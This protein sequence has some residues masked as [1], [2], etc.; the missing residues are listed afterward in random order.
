MSN[1]PTRIKFMSTTVLSSLL[2]CSWVSSAVAMYSTVPEMYNEQIS[3]VPWHFVKS[4]FHCI[5]QLKHLRRRNVSGVIYTA[6]PIKWI[7]DN[8]VMVNWSVMVWW[9]KLTVQLTNRLKFDWQ[10]DIWF[11]FY[12]QLK[13][14]LIVLC[15]V[16]D[17]LFSPFN[18]IVLLFSSDNVIKCAYTAI[19]RK[20]VAKKVHATISE[21]NMGYDHTV[22]NDCSC[23]T[24]FCCLPLA[25]ANICPWPPVPFFQVSL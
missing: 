5:T 15:F 16:Q 3:P 2:A 22:P 10:P 24:C 21:G 11:C 1:R 13:K 12:C 18:S 25:L 9:G 8:K 14:D 17:P 6:I 20:V 7:N 19:S 4:R 23:R